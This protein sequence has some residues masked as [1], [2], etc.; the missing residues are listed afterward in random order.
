M[1]NQFKTVLIL[2]SILAG[3]SVARNGCRQCIGYQ[4]IFFGNYVTYEQALGFFR[5]SI[6]ACATGNQYIIDSVQKDECMLPCLDVVQ[7]PNIT[8]CRNFKEE[9]C[10]Y[11]TF[12]IKVWRYCGNG[13]KALLSKG[14]HH[15]DNVYASADD[16]NMTCYRSVDC[17]GTCTPSQ[18]WLPHQLIMDWLRVK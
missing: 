14:Y 17:V 11:Y 4:K 1:L 9:V 16:L 12:N 10:R 5:S 8:F 18:C 3:L 2:L 13:G 7:E 15:I 6:G